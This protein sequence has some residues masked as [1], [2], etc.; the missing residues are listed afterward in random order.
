M[1]V[2]YVELCN[3]LSDYVSTRWYRSPELLVG[4]NSYG[5]PVDMWAIG[6][7]VAEM[8][9]GNPLFAG[10]SDLDQLGLIVRCFGNLTP[11]MTDLMA[12][13]PLFVGVKTPQC[14][15]VESLEQ[16]FPDM[17]PDALKL[18]KSC[19][20]YEPLQRAACSELLQQRYFRGAEETFGDEIRAAV[21][22]DSALQLMKMRK[23]Q[24]RQQKRKKERDRE[25]ASRQ[26]ERRR[27][28]HIAD[29]GGSSNHYT[30]DGLQ[31][32][33]VDSV[34]YSV[35]GDE[36]DPLTAR[37]TA[38]RR[39]HSRGNPMGGGG[40]NGSQ[41]Q[42]VGLN[43]SVFE[44]DTLESVDGGGGDRSAR[45]T[46][47]EREHRRSRLKEA[48]DQKDKDRS[49]SRSR[50]RDHRDRDHR[51][52]DHRDPALDETGGSRSDK[53]EKRRKKKTKAHRSVEAAS[54]TGAGLE[55]DGDTPD[56]RLPDLPMTTR[57]GRTSLPRAVALPHLTSDG[58]GADM[59][60]GGSGPPSTVTGATAGAPG[61][62]GGSGGGGADILMLDVQSNAQGGGNSGMTGGAIGGGGGGV[63][64]DA[65][66]QY[67]RGVMGGGF[68]GQVRREA[69]GYEDMD[70][71]EAGHPPGTAN[72]SVDI[73][74]TRG[75]MLGGPLPNVQSRG[76]AAGTAVRGRHQGHVRILHS[77]HGFPG[78]GSSSLLGG[79]HGLAG[80]GNSGGTYA[81]GQK[82]VGSTFSTAT[83]GGGGLSAI[84]SFSKPPSRQ[85]NSGGGVGKG[86][87]LMHNPPRTPT[88]HHQP[89]TSHGL[90]S[91]REQLRSSGAVG[92][93]TGLSTLAV[94]GKGFQ[95]APLGS[96]RRA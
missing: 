6:C 53:T 66:M 37:T 94:G 80:S 62:G 78:G 1:C 36:G 20:A 34:Q 70:S 9:T 47:H 29:D 75:Y 83:V 15:E 81:G 25:R 86:A 69:N 31:Q 12:N 48:K 43:M 3:W 10:E 21:D 13:N 96:S 61:A 90:A 58:D 28:S 2:F 49:G 72:G 42:G 52:R 40:G 87:G 65:T 22:R 39:L 7:M 92:G 93:G 27:G 32:P 88:H 14:D 16:R 63:E 35:R 89:S 84:P 44:K 60:G 76:G 19:L 11:R 85:R 68:I 59:Q 73:T 18:M 64:R 30:P 82:Y 55:S 17:D 24:Q 33:S 56:D 23:R 4:D 79:S 57:G 50:D 95:Y 26:V 45:S 51:D 67:R 46:T 38:S 8:L 71:S 77:S 5:K 74:D 41:Y 91:L 54:P